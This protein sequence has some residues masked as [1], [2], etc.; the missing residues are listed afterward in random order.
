[1]S[2]LLKNRHEFLFLYDARDINP[3]GDPIDENKPR[4]DEE[5]GINIVTDVRLKR[6]IR[7]Y[8]SDYKGFE[9]FVKE[10]RKEDGTLKTKED[11]LND[12]DINNAKDLINKCIDIRL[13]GATAAVK[14]KTITFTGPIQF[15]FGR[16][17]HPVKLQYVKGTTVMPSKGA[18]GQGT[19]TEAYILPYSLIAF[20]GI[21]NENL[22]K[23]TQMTESDL[24]LLLEAMWNGT[25][26]LISRSKIGQ[27]PRLL[28]DIEYQENNFHLGD[29]DKFIKLE[30]NTE[31]DA[32]RDIS[33]INLNVSPLLNLLF[34]NLERIK[35][36]RFAR[37]ER[38]NS[39]PDLTITVLKEKTSVTAIEELT[40]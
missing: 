22:A 27:M 19:F 36:I 5:T 4:I 34:E 8:L 21:A 6:S 7:D 37:D 33:E 29:L 15:K 28:V 30:S 18:K 38:L 2:E 31:P 20:Y 35:K 40:Y 23:I 11:R 12:L 32:I 13:F 9:V 17:L 10:V 24:N 39:S 3:N 1:M 26:N 14:N 16:S 25:K